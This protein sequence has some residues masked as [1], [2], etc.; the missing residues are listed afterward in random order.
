MLEGEAEFRL[1]DE[2]RG[3]R[4]GDFVFVHP[5]ADAGAAHTATHVALS[6]NRAQE[7][8]LSAHAALIRRAFPLIPARVRMR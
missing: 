2:I 7:L 1:G 5:R 3:V 4:V 6:W 8:E